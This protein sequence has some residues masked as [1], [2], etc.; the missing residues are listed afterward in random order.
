MGAFASCS[1]IGRR[2]TDRALEL[3]VVG[4]LGSR[5]PGAGF[6]RGLATNGFIGWLLAGASVQKMALSITN[7][8]ATKLDTVD[9]LEPYIAVLKELP[10]V[11]DVL[12][13]ARE[14]TLADHRFDGQV[15]V[16]T[17]EGQS[18]F[19]VE[20]KRSHLGQEVAER[21]LSIRRD[22]PNLLLFCPSVGRRLAER[23]GREGLNFVDLAGNCHVR[24]ADQYLAHVEG[25]RGDAKPP[26]ERG[27]R[28]QSYRVLFAMLVQPELTKATA[29]AIAEAAGGVSPQTAI[30]TRSRFVERGILLDTA[31][32]PVWAPRGWK[33]ALDLFIQGFMTT[34]AP[35]LAIG[36]F[37]AMQRDPDALEAE[38]QMR[39]A[40]LGDVEWRWGGGAAS[41]RMT[42]YFRGDQTVLYVKEARHGLA[43]LLH[44]R[45]DSEGPVRLSTA[46]GPLAFESAVHD[47]VHPLLAYVDLLAEGDERARDGAAEIYRRYLA[48]L[49]RAHR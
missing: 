29:R 2:W 27:L 13:N 25:R 39:L 45:P 10:F 33:D 24:I 46:P 8:H 42:G 35:Q 31:R 5:R 44:L 14:V 17:P 36:R 21:V 26:S 12:V 20:H 41:A 37:R 34:L 30:D 38:L 43:K 7:G 32:G 3:R 47:C 49:E 48:P 40:A 19:L 23:F 18:V 4:A 15:E 22:V 11:R 9:A 16:W 28:A 1:G 6:V